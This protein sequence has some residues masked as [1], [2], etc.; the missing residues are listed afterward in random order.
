M[1]DDVVAETTSI[2]FSVAPSDGRGDDV[3]GGSRTESSGSDHNGAMQA[4][5]G[6]E[7]HRIPTIQVPK[8]ARPQPPLLST[9]FGDDASVDRTSSPSAS[10]PL[11]HLE[12]P[13]TPF[14]AIR[15]VELL[16]KEHLSS[17]S[18]TRDVSLDFVRAVQRLDS[19]CVHRSRSHS[20]D[21]GDYGDDDSDCGGN[22]ATAKQQ[23][24]QGAE[25]YATYAGKQ[26]SQASRGLKAPPAAKPRSPSLTPPPRE[27]LVLEQQPTKASSGAAAT[28]TVIT[29]TAD[30]SIHF[31]ETDYDAEEAMA[32]PM[33]AAAPASPPAQQ[34]GNEPRGLSP[35][36]SGNNSPGYTVSAATAATITGTA[37][38]GGATL[39]TVSFM[40]HGLVALHEAGPQHS[41]PHPRVLSSSVQNE[42]DPM[43]CTVSEMTMANPV[44]P[45]RGGLMPLVGPNTGLQHARGAS[46][47]H[48]HPSPSHTSLRPPAAGRQVQS[49]DFSFD[50]SNALLTSNT[51][52]E[53]VKSTAGAPRESAYFRD[54]AE[55]A[56]TSM[57]TQSMPGLHGKHLPHF[58]APTPVKRTAD[59]R[60]TADGGRFSQPA[61][62][63]QGQRPYALEEI[64]SELKHHTESEKAD[65][66]GRTLRP[67]STQPPRETR[68][69]G[70]G[71][72]RGSRSVSSILKS[73]PSKILCGRSRNSVAAKS[74]VDER[75]ECHDARTSLHTPSSTRSTR[76][77]FAS[78]LARLSSMFKGLVSGAAN[79]SV[80]VKTPRSHP[81]SSSSSQQ[82]QQ[83]HHH[84]HHQQQQ[85]QQRL[86]PQHANKAAT[87]AVAA[88]SPQMAALENTISITNSNTNL[89][90]VDVPVGPKQWQPPPAVTPSV[91]SAHAVKSGRTTP[92][93]E[94]TSS[95]HGNLIDLHT[96]EEADRGCDDGVV[97][98]A[99]PIP[100]AAA[101]LAMPVEGASGRTEET[102]VRCRKKDAERPEHRR[103]HHRHHDAET[104]DHTS[105]SASAAVSG[106]GKRSRNGSAGGVDAS[107]S[108]EPS[109]PALCTEKDGCQGRERKRR[110]GPQRPRRRREG[111]EQRKEQV[112]GVSKC[113]QARST[114]PVPSLKSQSSEGGASSDGEPSHTFL[115]HCEG[116][117]RHNCTDDNADRGSP[118]GS[119]NKDCRG[120][121]VPPPP[122]PPQPVASAATLAVRRRE[123]R[124]KSRVA[125]SVNHFA[126]SWH[127]RQ[128]AR[129]RQ[130]LLRHAERTS[131]ARLQNRDAVRKSGSDE[132]ASRHASRS[133]RWSGSQRSAVKT[134]Q[135]GTALFSQQQQRKSGRLDQY[136]VA[137]TRDILQLDVM[138][139]KLRRRQLWAEASSE[140]AAAAE[141]TPS[142]QSLRGAELRRAMATHA[143][144]AGPLPSRVNIT[145]IA[146]ASTSARMGKSSTGNNDPDA[147]PR[148]SQ[149]HNNGRRK[150]NEVKSVEADGRSGKDVTSPAQQQP[151][152][153]AACTS[154]ASTS[155]SVLGAVRRPGVADSGNGDAEADPSHSN[156]AG[157]PS[158]AAQLAIGALQR[159]YEQLLD[160]L[161]A[162][163]ASQPPATTESDDGGTT[164]DVEVSMEGYSRHIHS[165][166]RHLYPDQHLSREQDE[167]NR[168][169]R[170]ASSSSTRGRRLAPAPAQVRKTMKAEVA[171]CAAALRAE[172]YQSQLYAQNQPQVSSKTIERGIRRPAAQETGTDTIPMAHVAAAYAQALRPSCVACRPQELDEYITLGLLSMMYGGAEE[173]A[174]PAAVF[175]S[176]SSDNVW[177]AHV[178]PVPTP[179]LAQRRIREDL[180]AAPRRC[181]RRQMGQAG[182]E[183]EAFCSDGN[184]ATESPIKSVSVSR[185]TPPPLMHPQSAG[186]AAAAH[187]IGLSPQA[188]TA[189][190]SPVPSAPHPFTPT[191]MVI[192]GALLTKLM[193]REHRARRV[194]VSQEEEARYALQRLY[195]VETILVL[196]AAGSA[197]VV[198][199]QDAPGEPALPT[200]QGTGTAASVPAHDRRDKSSGTHGTAPVV[201]TDTDF[202][203]GESR[204]TE[205]QSGY[206]AA[207]PLRMQDTTPRSSPE[208][209]WV[210]QSGV[211][212][213]AVEQ[214]AEDDSSSPAMRMAL[215]S[216]EADATEVEDQVQQAEGHSTDFDVTEERSKSDNSVP[217]VLLFHVED[218]PA[219][220][221]LHNPVVASIRAAAARP[222]MES[223]AMPSTASSPATER[224][225]LSI[226]KGE[227]ITDSDRHGSVDNADGIAGTV[228]DAPNGS[229]AASAPSTRTHTDAVPHRSP[230]PVPPSPSAA[231]SASLLSPHNLHM[232][233]GEG[234]VDAAPNG[235]GVGAKNLEA[236]A[237]DAV[238]CP[239]GPVKGAVNTAMTA[240]AAAGT[241]PNCEQPASAGDE[242]GQ[243][244]EDSRPQQRQQQRPMATGTANTAVPASPHRVRFSFLPGVGSNS[245]GEVKE[246]SD[247]WK[248]TRWE[249]QETSH[250]DRGPQMGTPASLK[251]ADSGTVAAGDEGHLAI[252]LLEKLNGLDALLLSSFPDYFTT[253]T[254]E[255]GLP[256]VVTRRHPHLTESIAPLA[257]GRN[258]LLSP[259]ARAAAAD[260]SPFDAYVSDLRGH[261]TPPRLPPESLAS[262]LRR[263]YGL[264]QPAQQRRHD[265]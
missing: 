158:K 34:P 99:P 139:E 131:L 223:L 200:S 4:G 253:G 63:Q 194:R 38:V 50:E 251:H 133:Q 151:N 43:Y 260:V 221:A 167:G 262:Q 142:R 18:L 17:P 175:A 52:R 112:N 16:L 111:Q 33:A 190:A 164:R 215:S 218:I 42:E 126:V 119:V 163:P 46:G 79:G 81:L 184:I 226:D 113:P 37:G 217:S 134:R 230:P 75:G 3:A 243:A 247:A 236:V 152:V 51:P 102:K 57:R 125:S 74:S 58:G 189:L 44:P 188:E 54:G 219:G 120:D 176:E 80:E 206:A 229:A 5:R 77:N 85:Q 22:G 224:Q 232:T 210:I 49:S 259:A 128:V 246:T 97:G 105:S 256:G 187:D 60:T 70:K 216:L 146:T 214:D 183:P 180:Y 209:D 6:D 186:A 244:P 82:Q 208:D 173:R 159:R 169:R 165:A 66:K 20:I 156:S 265:H 181:P 155:A 205:R 211:E 55:L 27:L 132:A 62:P 255:D 76:S 69:R 153:S 239:V 110:S 14:Q 137:L 118:S 148:L 140:A 185:G 12:K 127:T 86:A 10:P 25:G 36:S 92:T 11:A 170:V 39:P 84:H 191:P 78:G 149:P 29:T 171:R 90:S 23:C 108:S 123:L 196:R 197:A 95:W 231:S 71:T 129:H 174:N 213:D 106:D 53:V 203:S 263:K 252:D 161:V 91:T 225:P 88:A 195:V 264:P 254:D 144:T 89:R 135:S 24:P 21:N 26:A 109:A 30:E 204:D 2:D 96:D 104:R 228:E 41:T 45:Q 107:S 116:T 242:L 130:K 56:S 138:V 122:P 145:A 8:P 250:A 249:E 83:Q 73:F 136:E 117:L 64:A 238:Q 94:A 212:V 258:A 235:D 201:V 237:L 157:M 101:T 233:K 48:R 115:R 93:R 28:S 59:G 98:V 177:Q 1:E 40:S 248:Q 179:T 202:G 172:Y 227:H 47:G 31:E 168:N 35:S 222:F 192:Y 124:A 67:S 121:A 234:A 160:D 103:R 68:V 143:S 261:G 61:P 32:T 193:Q 178:R 15:P 150:A 245:D 198:L 72:D 240:A 65:E 147:S 114:S 162:P 154:H 87:V 199:E 100:P 141:A 7:R 19:E 166:R 220:A 13:I 241:M 182:G 9:P 207:A 257:E